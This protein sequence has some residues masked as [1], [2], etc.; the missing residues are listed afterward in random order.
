MKRALLGI[1]ALAFVGTAAWVAWD[2]HRAGQ[3]LGFLEWNETGSHEFVANFAGLY[4]VAGLYLARSAFSGNAQAQISGL[5]ILGVLGTGLALGRLLAWSL[6]T[7]G[8]NMQIGFFVWEAL[9]AVLVCLVLRST[10]RA[11]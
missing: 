6:G 4:G 3:A 1:N 9:T 8:A 10:P 5:K 2:F 11:Q 7:S